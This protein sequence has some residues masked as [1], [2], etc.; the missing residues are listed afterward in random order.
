[1]AAA[2]KKRLRS[3]TET[4]TRRLRGSVPF[5]GMRPHA[6]YVLASHISCLRLAAWTHSNDDKQIYLVSF[7]VHWLHVS[8]SKIIFGKT[9]GQKSSISTY[10]SILLFT[11]KDA[12]HCSSYILLG[13]VEKNNKESSP[14]LSRIQTLALPIHSLNLYHWKLSLVLVPVIYSSFK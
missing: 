7:R 12:V 8:R 1:M 10:L 11:Y 3:L 9:P 4:Q 6:K 14:P 2:A 5:P 13:L